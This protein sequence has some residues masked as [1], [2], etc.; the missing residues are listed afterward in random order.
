[1]VDFYSVNPD[2]PEMVHIKKTLGAAA[3]WNVTCVI[4]RAIQF[5]TRQVDDY[6]VSQWAGVRIDTAR[7]LLP[8]ITEILSKV[9]DFP[10]SSNKGE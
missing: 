4:T 7:K 6:C 10:A 2:C 8:Y 1:M 5:N 9:P 3:A